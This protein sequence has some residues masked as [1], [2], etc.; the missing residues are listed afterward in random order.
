MKSV[1]K[2]RA[3]SPTTYIRV[4]DGRPEWFV[5]DHRLSGA[6]GYRSQFAATR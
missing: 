6:A 4:F 3:A 5:A 1:G 2:I